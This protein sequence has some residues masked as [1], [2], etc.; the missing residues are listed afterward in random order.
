MQT[1]IQEKSLLGEG[2][3]NK[4]APATSIQ[5][6]LDACIA[7]SNAEQNIT[8]DNVVDLTGLKR[9]KVQYML[10]DLKTRGDLHSSTRGV[11]TLVE[12]HP[13]ARA[14]SLTIACNGMTK[15]EIG[16]EILE[17]TPAEARQIAMLFAGRAT[18]A[19]VIESSRAHMLLATE[20]SAQ[21]EKLKK[22]V[23]A[24]RQVQDKRQMALGL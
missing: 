16:D 8:A 11:Y 7:L 13:E 19:A 2:R 14:I 18:E 15:V 23:A 21:V 9:D 20:L 24:L 22:D 6:V 12:S 10:K 17:V 3:P 4:P 5:R 1:E